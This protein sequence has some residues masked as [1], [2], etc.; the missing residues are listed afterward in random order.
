MIEKREYEVLKQIIFLKNLKIGYNSDREC[1][2]IFLI[3]LSCRAA[4]RI[5]SKG[6][7]RE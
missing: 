2:F 6:H 7:G 1:A 5:K 3:T 4:K